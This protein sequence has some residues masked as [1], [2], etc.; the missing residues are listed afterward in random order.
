MSFKY[1]IQLETQQQWLL[2]A[3]ACPPGENRRILHKIKGN[4]VQKLGNAV[5][6]DWVAAVLISYLGTQPETVD[7]KKQT[8]LV[9]SWNENC[10]Y[11]GQIFDTFPYS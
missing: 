9:L 7:R 6:W 3:A 10:Y 8:S 4:L 5:D 11:L 1:F 2:Q